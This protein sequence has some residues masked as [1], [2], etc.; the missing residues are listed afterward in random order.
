MFERVYESVF[1]TVQT[2][3]LSPTCLWNIDSGALRRRIV[4]EGHEMLPANEQPIEAVRFLKEPLQRFFVT[5]RAHKAM[6]ECTR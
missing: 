3:A 4:P 6:N 2:R 1:K 5:V